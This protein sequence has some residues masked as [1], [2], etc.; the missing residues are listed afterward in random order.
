V[1]DSASLFSHFVSTRGTFRWLSALVVVSSAAA[2]VA[3]GFDI[4]E[5]RLLARS[6]GPGSITASERAAHAF[7]G[8]VVFEVQTALLAATA[9]AFVT[10]LYRARANLRAFGTRHLRFQR[11]WAIFGFVIPVLNLFRPYQVV[12][13]VWQASTPAAI[14]PVAW[15]GVAPSGL[16]ASWWG[17]FVA[18]AVI[19]SLAWWMQWS[20][21][22]DAMRLQIAHGVELLADVLAAISVTLVYFVI[23]RITDFQQAKWEQLQPPIP[24]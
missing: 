7:V 5:I 19:K 13:E 24:R 11:N 17:T 3:V 14:G 23:E 18:F 9:I 8:A 6:L 2:W 1:S 20:G 15:Q 12:Q 4:A 10:W 22:Y 16:V 21:S